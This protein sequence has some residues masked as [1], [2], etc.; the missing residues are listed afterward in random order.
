M[1]RE[2]YSFIFLVIRRVRVVPIKYL[3]KI[4]GPTYLHIVLD[5]Y[6]NSLNHSYSLNGPR[7]EKMV[8]I[9]I[10][11]MNTIPA[12]LSRG[13]FRKIYPPERV[14]SIHLFYLFISFTHLFQ[15]AINTFL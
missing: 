15:L 13:T 3:S 9:E 8:R 12:L 14:A 2:R 1:F 5:R 11:S 10:G 6:Q 7:S 4:T